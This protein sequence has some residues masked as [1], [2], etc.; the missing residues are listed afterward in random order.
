MSDFN[1][2]LAPGILVL[3]LT[4]GFIFGYGV[5]EGISYRRHVQADRR[6]LI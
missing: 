3:V 4:M 6:R 5:R 2:F 1:M